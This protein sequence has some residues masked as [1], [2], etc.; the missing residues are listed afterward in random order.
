M[1]AKGGKAY[2]IGSNITVIHRTLALPQAIDVDKADQVVEAIVCSYSRSF[3]DP[4]LG[5]L[6]ITQ[7]H[8]GPGVELI[9]VLAVE[10]YAHADRQALPERASRRPNPR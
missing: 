6:T 9:E 5:D 7:E 2:L 8:V 4:A 10:R 3:P 1:P